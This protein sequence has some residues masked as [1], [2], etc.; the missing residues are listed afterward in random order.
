[1]VS[2]ASVKAA[3]YSASFILRSVVGERLDIDPEELDISNVRQVEMPDGTKCAEIVLNDHLANGAGF[4]AWIHRNW[5]QIIGEVATARPGDGT[6][7]GALLDT[8]HRNCDSACYDCLKQYRNMSYHGLL[9]WRLGISVLRILHSSDSKVGIDGDFS[10]PE[11]DGWLDS[12][13]ALVHN[14]CSSFQCVP[15]D[16]GPLHGFEVGGRQVIVIHPLWNPD[17]PTGILAQAIAATDPN[18]VKF[19]DSFNLLRRPSFVYLNLA[20]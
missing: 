1:V 11:L 15:L 5:A 3:L 19:V 6:F 16:F 9:D 8:N 13:R 18:R 17:R 4:A 14:F 20:V 10:P 12:V 7:I 2:G